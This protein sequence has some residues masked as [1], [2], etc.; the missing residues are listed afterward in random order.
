MVQGDA[1][2]IDVHIGLQGRPIEISDIELVEITLINR[3]KVYPGEVTYSDGAFHYPVTQEETLNFPPLCSMQVRVKFKS[4]DVIGSDVQEIDVQ[5]V[6]SK[7]V[8]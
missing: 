2:S 7:V 1:Y 5:R 6:L 4:G 3:S 8:L